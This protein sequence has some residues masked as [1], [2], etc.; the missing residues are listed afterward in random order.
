MATTS[1]N[2]KP[3]GTEELWADTPYYKAK[4][5]YIEGGKRLSR[6]YHV[7]REHTIRILSGTLRIECGPNRPGDTIKV[8]HLKKGDTKTL[9]RNQVHRFCAADGGVRLVEVSNGGRDN[10]VRVEDDYGRITG[11]PQKLKQ[12]DK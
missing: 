9:S 10:Y 8:E 1:I 5:L 4:I 3:W 7:L 12:S 6:K 2:K 11:Y